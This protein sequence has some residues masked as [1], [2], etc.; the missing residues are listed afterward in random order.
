[1]MPF[2]GS[3][4]RI[5]YRLEWNFSKSTGK[6]RKTAESLHLDSVMR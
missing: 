4:D 1:M 3:S 2:A 6:A 5:F